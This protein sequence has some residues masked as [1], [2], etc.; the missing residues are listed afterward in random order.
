M[1]VRTDLTAHRFSR[2]WRL[3]LTCLA[4]AACISG[5][6]AR[7]IMSTTRPPLAFDGRLERS[8]VRVERATPRRAPADTA[9][10]E[11]STSSAAALLSAT[12]WMPRI[13]GCPHDSVSVHGVRYGRDCVSYPVPA[14]GERQLAAAIATIDRAKH[15]QC[16]RL[17]DSIQRYV[18]E[19]WVYWFE[20][21]TRPMLEGISHHNAYVGINLRAVDVAETVRHEAAHLAGFLPEKDADWMAAYC[22]L[23]DPSEDGTRLKWFL[24]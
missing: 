12:E 24:L 16:Q 4:A 8:A 15:P 5:C 1:D 6:S 3:F 21:A 11:T 7:P 10:D 22:R 18:R 19:G 17:H 9:T 23:G 14:S 2:S 20:E 13:D